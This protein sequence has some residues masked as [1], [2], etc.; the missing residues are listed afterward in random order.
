MGELGDVVSCLFPTTATLYRRSG[1]EIGGTQTRT[2]YAAHLLR[3]LGTACSGRASGT[4][5]SS[6]RPARP[7]D[8]QHLHALARGAQTRHGASGP[9]VP[10]AQTFRGMLE[11]GELIS[12]VLDDG[13]VVYDLSDGA[14]TVEHLVAGSPESAATLWGL[15][16]SGSSAAPTVHTYLDPRDPVS[17]A[18]GGMQ[19]T[20]VRQTPWMARVIDLAAAFAGRGF[21]AHTTAGAELVVDDAEAPSNSGRWSLTVSGGRGSAERVDTDA[22]AER[23]RAGEGALHVGARGLSALW[24]GWS[25]SRL[26][27]AGLATGGSAECDAALDA[28]FAATPYITEYF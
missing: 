18:L 27:Q 6:V 25:V 13:F 12:Y 23:T 5:G 20:E 17:L 4:G 10:T 11:R 1:F 24:C 9:M 15:V 22:R 16:G 3:A 28:V 19:A 8:A 2:T 7:D 21:S 14:V 26:R